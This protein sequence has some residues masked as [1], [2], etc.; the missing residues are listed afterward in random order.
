MQPPLPSQAATDYAETVLSWAAHV[1]ASLVRQRHVPYGPDGAQRYDVY[2][3][4]G[5]TAL[6]ALVFWHG[7]GWTHGFREWCAF[8]AEPVA[9]LGLRLVTP[10]YRLAP[11]HPLP[12][13]LHDSQ[14]MLDH[15]AREADGL[16]I[17]RSR[18]YLAGHSAGGHLA[19]LTALRR[20]FHAPVGD[21][22]AAVIRAC[23]P[24][25]G[26]L[27][28]HHPTPQP[29]SLEE[30][31]YTLVLGN[32]LDDAALSPLCW[33]A[34][35][36]LPI[37]LSHGEGDSE[38]VIR[39]NQRMAALLAQQP[40]ASELHC[41]AGHDHFSTHTALRDSQAPWYARLAELVRRAA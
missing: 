34:G 23:L 22:P 13:A 19:L 35:N 18:L 14:M 3:E 37:L 32:P 11:D 2:G 41:E 12:A 8:M 6:P 20:R 9:R 26:I 38:R 39:S 10:G 17:D 33:A 21:T 1:P 4:A 24:I 16:G 36:S 28:L 31:V 30:R 15:L 7:G 5:D 29:G 27:D 25:S 40:G